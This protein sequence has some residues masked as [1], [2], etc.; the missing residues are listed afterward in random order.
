MTYAAA[1]PR[2]GAK[3]SVVPAVVVVVVVVVEL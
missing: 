3:F 2:N 1:Q